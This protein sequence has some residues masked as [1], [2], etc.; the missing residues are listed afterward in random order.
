MRGTRIIRMI[1]LTGI[2]G[3][4]FGTDTRAQNPPQAQTHPQLRS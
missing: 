4:L 1:L 3:M 2:A